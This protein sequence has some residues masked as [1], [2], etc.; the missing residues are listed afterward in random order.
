MIKKQY[1]Y[2]NTSN[3]LLRYK[4]VKVVADYVQIILSVFQYTTVQYSTLQRWD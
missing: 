3:V 1:I 2:I 4:N